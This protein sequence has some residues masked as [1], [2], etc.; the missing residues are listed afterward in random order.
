[1]VLATNDEQYSPD[2]AALRNTPYPRMT[3][4]PAISANHI[5]IKL[6]HVMV[7][8]DIYYLSDIRRAGCPWGYK[9]LGNEKQPHL[10]EEWRILHARG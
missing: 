5:Q 2:V 9:N 7:E 1:M 10:P 8:K 4:P 3:T 6:S